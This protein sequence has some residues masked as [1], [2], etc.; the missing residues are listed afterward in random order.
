MNSRGLLFT[1]MTLFMIFGIIA[2]NESLNDVSRDFS[3]SASVISAYSA[4]DSFRNAEEML[5]D[6]DL[7][8][9]SKTAKERTLPFVYNFDKD[10]NFL[11][12][13]QEISLGSAQIN[14]LFSYLNTAAV[15]L[16]DTNYS[17]SF[18]GTVLLVSP[19]KNSQWGGSQK[20]ISFLVNP[21]CY[22]YVI[23]DEFSSGFR[24]SASNK[25]SGVFSPS[26]IRRFDINITIL[27]SLSDFNSF[28]CGGVSCPNASF[29]PADS[30]PFYNISLIDS[31][32]PNCVLPSKTASSHFDSFSDLNFTLACLGGACSSGELL[33]TLR[34]LDLN[35]GYSSEQKLSI[36]TKVLFTSNPEE[37]FISD[38]NLSASTGTGGAVKSNN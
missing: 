12:V 21:Q 11:S 6:L 37:F 32:C 26:S 27:S 14:D 36:M 19:P 8:G 18:N 5:Y 35:F 13:T 28:L 7:E 16:S 30:R 9:Y 31:N 4:G 17:N 38:V 22:E 23:N 24:K 20:S 25:C 29:N 15:F 33:V 2:L 3:P 34:D 10:S 1:V